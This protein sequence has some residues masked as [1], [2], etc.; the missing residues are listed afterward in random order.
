MSLRI[1]SVAATTAPGD[2][3]RQAIECWRL[4][5]GSCGLCRPTHPKHSA[6]AGAVEIA[7]AQ[8]DDLDGAGFR[9]RRELLFDGVFLIL[10]LAAEI[11]PELVK[12]AQAGGI[13]PDIVTDQTSAH[14]II[15]GYLPVGWTVAQWQ[16]A[17][18]DPAQ[19]AALDLAALT[20]DVAGQRAPPGI[21][22]H[23]VDAAGVVLV[24]V[25]GTSAAAPKVWPLLHAP[26]VAVAEPFHVKSP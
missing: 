17:Q 4:H 16:A 26:E 15:N 20:G 2:T 11:V 22:A 21:R 25:G 24:T 8:D 18:K 10:P 1:C 9:R 19:H 3:F 23:L 6:A 14:D 12:R 7:G 13:R 5:P